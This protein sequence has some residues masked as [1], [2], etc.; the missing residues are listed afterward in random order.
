MPKDTSP[1]RLRIDI[2]SDIC[3]CDPYVLHVC[4]ATEDRVTLRHSSRDYL[5][6]VGCS[7][8]FGP[9]LYGCGCV[10]FH[11]RVVLVVNDWSNYFSLESLVR[12]HAD[13]CAFA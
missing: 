10:C 9:I 1:S 7:E 13:P 11:S 12:G 5:G 2:E 6:S 8:L 4:K 3:L